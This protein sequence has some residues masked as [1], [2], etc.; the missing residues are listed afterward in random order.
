[1]LAILTLTWMVGVIFAILSGLHVYWVL[2]GTWGR[3][4]AI[5][6][7]GKDRLFEPGKI[8]TLVIALL[9]ALA[10]WFVL[11]LGGV[12]RVL[13]SLSLLSYGA[14]VLSILFMIRA[15]GDFRWVGFFKRKKG[16]TFAKWDS[17]LFSPL[18]LFL[19]SATLII[20]F[21]RTD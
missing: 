21:L 5:P 19:T 10:A 1:M 7:T 4:A 16:T 18:C 9:L 13:F 2:G 8:G 6:H 15:V 17:I 3:E 14:W 12:V 11:E 20:M